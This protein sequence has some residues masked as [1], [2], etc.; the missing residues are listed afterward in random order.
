SSHRNDSKKKYTVATRGTMNSVPLKK[1]RRILRID[2]S[3]GIKIK[4]APGF[5]PGAV[6]CFRDLPGYSAIPIKDLNAKAMSPVTNMV[7]PNPFRGA[8]TLEY[9]IFSRIAASAVIASIQPIP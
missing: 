4:K 8:G 7:I 2:F 3:I 5:C 6:Q 9:F 1:Y